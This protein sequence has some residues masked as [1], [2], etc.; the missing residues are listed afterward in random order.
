[1]TVPQQPADSFHNYFGAQ[2]ADYQTY[3]PR[4]PQSLFTYL[5]TSVRNTRLAWDC[6]TGNGQAAAG[7]AHRFARVFATDPSADMIANAIEHPRVTYAVAKY[8]T[9]LADASVSLITVAQALHWFDINAFVKEAR[10]VLEPDGVFA[11]FCYTRC[12]LDEE[13]D[14][15]VEHF[16]S[17]TVGAYWPPERRLADEGYRTIALPLD[18]ML[19]P[20]CE[21]IEDWTLNSF[22]RFVR[23]WSAV[24]RCIAAKGEESVVAFESEIRSLW[25]PPESKRRIRWPM[26]FRVGQ[27][28]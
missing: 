14:G 26:H 4:Y 8:Q 19:V 6:A 20:P 25:G 9:T 5:A 23:T 1:M 2:A 3:R 17:V 12:R 11:A 13:L 10:R 15:V 28:R 27:L 24:A 21:M 16:F 7:L 22:L 18:E